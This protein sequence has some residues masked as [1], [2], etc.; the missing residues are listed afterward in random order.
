MNDIANA[1]STA[2]ARLDA[3]MDPSRLNDNPMKFNRSIK[4]SE[5]KKIL[6]SDP[7]YFL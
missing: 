3:P 1:V 7:D 2:F 5:M 4:L 6:R